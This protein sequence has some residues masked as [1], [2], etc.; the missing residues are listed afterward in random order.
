MKCRSSISSSIKNID[1]DIIK[2]Q[3]NVYVNID[4][5]RSRAIPGKDFKDLLLLN[6]FK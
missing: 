1:G 3:V 4:G 5:I 6:S 2:S